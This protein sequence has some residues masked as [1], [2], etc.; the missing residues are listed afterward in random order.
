[1]HHGPP[2]SSIIRPPSSRSIRSTPVSTSPLR[3]LGSGPSSRARA[4]GL[5]P[6][7]AVGRR[8][9]LA[10]FLA[11]AGRGP[12]SSC[13]P[14]GLAGGTRG[15]R[16]WPR[17]AMRGLLPAAAPNRGRNAWR[18][19]EHRREDLGQVLFVSAAGEALGD[20]GWAKASVSTPSANDSTLALLSCIQATRFARC[21][22]AS[23]G[24]AGTQGGGVRHPSPRFRITSPAVSTGA[25]AGSGSRSAARGSGRTAR[26]GRFA[27]ATASERAAGAA[28]RP[29]RVAGA[30]V[31]WAESP[32]RGSALSRR[33]SR[34]IL[35]AS[36]PSPAPAGGSSTWAHISSSSSRGDVAPRISTSP[37]LMTSAALVKDAWPDLAAGLAFA[38]AGLPAR[39]S[40]RWSRRPARPAR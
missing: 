12:G 29:G 20:A 23:T 15:R 40:G 37:A 32:G 21:T 17:S 31:G 10:P 8:D 5:P 16:W 13:S 19:P 18:R 22:A 28:G 36:A 7:R 39:R 27:G 9:A 38:R 3:S 11:C 30:A 25:D 1:M 26:S 4:T 34:S 2:V 14:A 24:P 33:S 6:G 35:S